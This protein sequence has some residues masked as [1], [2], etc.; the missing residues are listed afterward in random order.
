MLFSK[1]LFLVSAGLVTASPLDDRAICGEGPQRV[2]YG[3]DGGESQNLNPADVQYVADYLRYLGDENEGDAKFWNMPKGHRLR[4]VDAAYRKR[5]HPA[6]SRKAH[7][8]T[9]QVVDSIRRFGCSYRRWPGR[10]RRWKEGASW[11]W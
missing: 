2:C 5:R 6:C 9:G 7:Q 8:R 11:L 1:S 3:I 10:A 4:R